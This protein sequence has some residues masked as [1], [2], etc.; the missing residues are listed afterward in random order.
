VSAARAT[1]GAA[2]GP[3]GSAGASGHELAWLDRACELALRGRGRCSPNPLV[4]A[5]LAREGAVLGEGWHEGPGTAHAEVA[6]LRA[7]RAAGAEPRGA[8]MA[9][10]LEP[11][12][13]HGR[14]PPCVDAILEAGV[15]R[16]VVGCLDP[17]ERRRGQGA[18]LLAEAGVEIVLAE[19]AA[20]EACRE[21]ASAFLTWAVTGRPAV[22]LKLATSLDGKVATAGG[23]T[24]WI[25][26]PAARA[27]VHRWRADHDA[28][29]VGIGTAL[30]DDPLLTARDVP[31]EVRQPLRVVFD[32]TARLPLDA[33]LVR[34]AGETPTLVVAGPA[35]PEE[36]VAALR[37]AGAEVLRLPDQDEGAR[38]VA[39]LDALGE[40]EVQS[41]FLEGGP[42]LAAGFLAAGLVDRVEWV[43]APILIG[44]ADAP[45]A[46]AGA[47]LHRLADAPRL[48]AP[49]VERLGEDVLVSGRL[50]PVPG[51]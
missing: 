39:A 3:S 32:A 31:G 26:G 20:A 30:A 9:V 50:R 11:C 8:T 48:I 28:V 35:A 36:R 21:A 7:A 33:A 12:S 13:H 47:G 27:L 41:L 14:T 45:G 25:S 6:A 16:V 34:G 44:G 10:T 43:L 42:R 15:A 5:V 22:T 37:A 51:G 46:L 24:R 40:R 38:L 29:A 4:G 18:R 17:L 23:E 49:R 1:T 2:A 19:G